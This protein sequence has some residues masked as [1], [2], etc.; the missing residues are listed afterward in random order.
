[1]KTILIV[2]LALAL[3]GCDKKPEP[4]AQQSVDALGQWQPD[5]DGPIAELDSLLQTL[6][7]QQH[8]NRVA[9]QL[10]TLYD[11]KLYQLYLRKLA[12]LEGDA[13]RKLQ[14]EQRAWLEERLRI[15]RAAAEQF[16]SG[17]IASFISSQ[18]F[19][20]ETRSRMEAFETR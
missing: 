15:S 6:N 18:A 7:Q 10:A 14:E 13:R 1:M 20:D 16:R 8:I 9:G 12:T 2:V 5:L 3:A 4:V 19:I 11:A 17:S